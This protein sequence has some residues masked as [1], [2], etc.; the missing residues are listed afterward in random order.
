MA[1]LQ[2][3]RGKLRAVFLEKAKLCAARLQALLAV[4]AAQ[5]AG[6]TSAADI[7]AGLG[8]AAAFFR[9][10]PLEQA[11]GR[12]ARATQPLDRDRQARSATTLAALEQAL[13]D[14]AEQPPLVLFHS[15]ASPLG[16]AAAGGESRLSDDPCSAALEFSRQRL[17]RWAR[18]A[19]TLR[20]ARLEIAGAFDAAR[21]TA[22]FARFD[23]QTAE[24]EELAACAAVAVWE[25]AEKLAGVSLA[26]YVRLLRSGYPVHILAPWAGLRLDPAAC[27][28]ELGLF[29]MLHRETLVVQSSL[30]RPDHVRAGLAR[31][32]ASLRPSVAVVAEASA[33]LAMPLFCFDPDRGS[34]LWEQ[35]VLAPEA[36]AELNPAA[37]LIEMRDHIRVIPESAWNDD[38]IEWTQYLDRYTHA[39]PLSIPFLRVPGA[40]D[41]EQRA[42]ITRELVHLLRD[43][44]RSA[45][46]LLEM[47]GG[48]PRPVS[49]GVEQAKRDGA[50]EAIQQV[51]VLLGSAIPHA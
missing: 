18:L 50:A 4:D 41:G 6:T 29:S 30:H 3:S 5:R 24:A 13:R 32:T 9:A 42:V 10:D 26:S 43:R 11:F 14:E 51:L 23:W 19:R 40:R 15:D 17:E 7:T 45:E 16:L 33:T 37:L 49:T 20:M 12:E 1:A 46:M 39:P 22:A 34:T 35:L 27:A 36:A 31:M 8:A 28:A 48:A 47:A 2:A 21:H 44:R 38:Q 25:P